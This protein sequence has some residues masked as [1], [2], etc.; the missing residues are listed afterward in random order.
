[1]KITEE[2]FEEVGLALKDTLDVG[3][4]DEAV[5]IFEKMKE[6]CK[7]HQVLMDKFF[8][9]ELKDL[10]RKS[11]NKRFLERIRREEEEAI[12]GTMSQYGISDS[13]R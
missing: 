11:F 3:R 1:M 6:I 12:R 10:N 5:Q 7:R 8:V 13:K 4:L 9:D 2:E